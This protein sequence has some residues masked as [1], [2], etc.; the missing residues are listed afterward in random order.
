[1][2]GLLI[3]LRGTV[4]EIKSIKKIQKDEKADRVLNLDLKI[5]HNYIRRASLG[6][7]LFSSLLDF[8]KFLF[9][10]SQGESDF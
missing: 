5:K 8:L 2:Q 3:L 1:M 10:E 9:L 6:S 7:A 4:G